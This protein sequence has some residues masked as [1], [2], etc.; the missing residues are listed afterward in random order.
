MFNNFNNNDSEDIE[1]GGWLE[2]NSFRSYDTS[3]LEKQIKNTGDYSGFPQKKIEEISKEIKYCKHK[4]THIDSENSIFIPKSGYSNV[5]TKLEETETKHHNLFKISFDEKQIIAEYARYFLN[6]DI[7]KMYRKSLTRGMVIKQIP[8]SELK[9]LLIF[10]PDLKKQKEL[11]EIS[12][13]LNKVIAEMED[14]KKNLSY[15]PKQSKEIFKTSKSYFNKLS[16]ITKEDKIKKII[17]SGETKTIEFKETFSF[18]KHT[19]EKRADYLIKS[20]CKNI[21]GFINT[22]GG[23]LF[24]GVN[25]DGQ[26]IGI[27]EELQKHKSVDA[28]KLF[29]SDTIKT[30][31][32]PLYNTNVDFKIHTIDNKKIATNY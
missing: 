11:I 29:L 12:N 27:E 18:N 23:N 4:E 32:G 10:V 7:G 21:V 17:Q 6:T 20:T 14:L 16:E 8:L 19:N 15:Y 5:I 24:I 9:Q 2:K 25:D 13:Y 26:I 31:I 1:V 28:F 3:L 22:D 30:K